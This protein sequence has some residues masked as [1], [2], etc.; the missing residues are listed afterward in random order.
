[1]LYIIIV[2]FFLIALFEVYEEWAFTWPFR[3]INFYDDREESEAMKKKLTKT[4]HDFGWYAI[5]TTGALVSSSAFFIYSGIVL[6]VGHFCMYLLA[7]M[8]MYGN[9]FNIGYALKI[10][11]EWYYLGT[12]S[13]ED[14]WLI[15]TLGAKAGKYIVFVSIFLLVLIIIFN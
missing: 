8:I 14:H 4:F 2:G 9:T 15:D 11:R 7:S 3:E 1:M 6:Q 12:T 10:N 5:I 13:K